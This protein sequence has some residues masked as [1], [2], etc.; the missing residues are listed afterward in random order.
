MLF[1][2]RNKKSEV[3][4]KGFCFIMLISIYMLDRHWLYT[5]GPKMVFGAT[6][7]A[8]MGAVRW[9]VEKEE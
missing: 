4:S 3:K 5:F 7:S 2:F 8:L 9:R 1:S 6:F